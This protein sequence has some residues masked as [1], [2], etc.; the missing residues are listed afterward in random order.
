M[1]IVLYL[2]HGGNPP[3]WASGVTA[4]SPLF[5]EERGGPA[6][7]QSEE[8]RAAG[9]L[10]GHRSFYKI[11]NPTP[12]SAFGEIQV[13]QSGLGR[14][15]IASRKSSFPRRSRKQPTPKAPSTVA[16]RCGI[17]CPRQVGQPRGFLFFKILYQ[18]IMNQAA[19]GRFLFS[20]IW[21]ACPYSTVT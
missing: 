20:G 3:V 7:L 10:S 8:C 18:S 9:A 12:T 4:A 17:S 1:G 15:F 14:R 6:H 19:C 2:K 11:T 13:S 21:R 16:T 5:P